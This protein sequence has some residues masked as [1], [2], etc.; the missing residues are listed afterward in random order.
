M[1]SVKHPLDMLYGYIVVLN[2]IT[3]IVKNIIDNRS[4]SVLCKI[5]NS[6]LCLTCMGS[7]IYCVPFFK[8]NRDRMQ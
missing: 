2:Y 6:W 8:K 3:I 1:E 7:Y 5:Y 4:K